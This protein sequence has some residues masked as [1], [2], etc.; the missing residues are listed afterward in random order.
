MER[1]I[2]RPGMAGEA[3]GLCGENC[4]RDEGTGNEVYLWEEINSHGFQSWGD[5]FSVPQHEFTYPLRR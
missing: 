5:H 4:P 3:G 1:V 2:P